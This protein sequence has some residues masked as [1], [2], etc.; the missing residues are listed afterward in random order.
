MVLLGHQPVSSWKAAHW[1]AISRSWWGLGGER[2]E[3]ST[4]WPRAL[5]AGGEP[6]LAPSVGAMHLGGWRCLMHSREGRDL[7]V[8]F[9]APLGSQASSRGEAKEAL[10]TWGGDLCVSGPG[11]DFKLLLSMLRGLGRWGPVLPTCGPRGGK[12]RGQGCWELAGCSVLIRDDFQG[13]H[14]LVLVSLM[15]SRLA[16]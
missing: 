9:Q 13:L 5:R 2:G 11:R 3:L 7:G 16:T 14:S 12:H 1:L 10:M 15:P 4:G 6:R 8:A